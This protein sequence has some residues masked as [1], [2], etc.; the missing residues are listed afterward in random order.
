MRCALSF[1]FNAIVRK[2]ISR[3][4]HVGVPGEGENMKASGWANRAGSRGMEKGLLVGVALLSACT[5]T[6]V[7]E[8]LTATVG[9]ND[10][11]SQVEFWHGLTDQRV[12]S[13]DDAFHA[14]VLFM[15][16]QD[17]AADY[18]GRVAILKERGMLP[19]GFDGEADQAIS[20]GT[21]AVALVKLLN[22]KGGVIMHVIGPAP[23][24]ATRELRYE[25]VYP[26][27]SEWQVFTGAQFVAVMGRVEDYQRIKSIEP[28]MQQLESQDAD[29]APAEDAPAEPVDDDAPA[30]A[31][32]RAAHTQ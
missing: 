32:A 26:P 12:T 5:T 29:D 27:S 19:G 23:R 25:G 3:T 9:G 2:G 24:Y 13:H 20:R 22:I 18:A 15:D 4:E 1:N 16:G 14:L 28:T 11:D 8:S 7:G 31:E 17:P 21:L 30:E 10:D 6:R